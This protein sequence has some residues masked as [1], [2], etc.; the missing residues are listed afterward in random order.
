M[1]I[2]GYNESGEIRV[3][4]EGADS[5]STIPNDMGNRHRQM[6]AEWEAAGNSIPP[7][8]PPEPTAPAISPLTARQLRLGLVMNGF[9]LDQVETAIVDIDDPEQRAVAS[10][11]WEYA[12][13]FERTHPLI[14]Q[15]GAALGLTDEQVDGMWEAA[16][17][18]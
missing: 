13:R 3:F 1:E 16:S 6:I 15:V 2:L 9:T 4:F 10:I 12:S 17:A 11:E 5:E 7:Y 8:V 18:L 14:A